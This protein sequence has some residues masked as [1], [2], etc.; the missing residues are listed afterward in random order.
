LRFA[1]FRAAVVATGA[2]TLQQHNAS[3]NDTNGSLQLWLPDTQLWPTQV[4]VGVAVI[5]LHLSM[6][7]LISYCRGKR[8]VGDR[9][10]QFSGDFSKFGQF[11][12]STLSTIAAGVTLGTSANANSLNNQT[13]GPSADTIAPSFPQINLGNLC[14]MQLLMQYTMLVNIWIK[15]LTALVS[16]AGAMEKSHQKKLEKHNSNRPMLEE[17]KVSVASKV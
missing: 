14:V 15:G 3:K 9:V 8:K 12:E 10:V 6:G 17:Q 11:L 2:Y 7:S 5:I 1:D 16:I 13:C 4:G